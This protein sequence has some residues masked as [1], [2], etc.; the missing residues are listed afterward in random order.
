MPI[1]LDKPNKKKTYNPKYFHPQLFTGSNGKVGLFRESNNPQYL[2]N[3]VAFP[4]ITPLKNKKE[5]NGNTTVTYVP[6]QIDTQNHFRFMQGSH[7]IYRPENTARI[8]TSADGSQHI[9][10]EIT[11]HTVIVKEMFDPITSK[12]VSTELIIL[13]RTIIWRTS[14]DPDVAPLTHKHKLTTHPF[15]EFEQILKTDRYISD[16]TDRDSYELYKENYSLYDAISR[17]AWVWNEDIAAEVKSMIETVANTS[18]LDT[19][20]TLIDIVRTLEDRPINLVAYKEIY[21][22]IKAVLPDYSLKE[23]IRE[24]INLLMAHTL[25]NLDDNRANVPAFP[26]AQPLTPKNP[27]FSKTQ[28]AALSSDAPFVL[29]Q[30][31][32]GSGKTQ[33]LLGRVEHLI[34]RGVDPASITVLSFTNAAAD[35]VL[36][37]NPNVRS[38]TISKM[39]HDIYTYN[40]DHALS[41]VETLINTIDIY[42]P[43]SAFARQFI[44][45]LHNFIKNSSSAYSQMNIF[46]EDNYDEIMS[47]L[48]HIGQTSLE[49]EIIAA[50]QKIDTYQI[51]P[52]LKASHLVIDEVQDTSIF[53]FIYLLK[54]AHEQNATLFLVGDSSQTLFEFRSANPRAINALEA[55][56]VFETYP[57]ETNYRSNQE[58]LDF[59]NL[60]LKDIEA[61]QYA[62]LT[63]QANDL[64]PVTHDSFTKKVQLHYER[65]DRINDMEDEIGPIIRTKVK[66]YIDDIFAR[67]EKVAFLAYTRKQVRFFQEIVEDL[68]PQRKIVSLVPDR[69]YNSTLFSMFLRKYGD[70]LQYMPTKNILAVIEDEI[71][72]RLPLLVKYSKNAE[73]P[74]RNFIFQYKNARRADI[75]GWEALVAQGAMTHEEFIDLLKQ[76]MLSYEISN[77]TIRQALLNQHNE[78]KKKSESI[79]DAD[80]ILSTIHSA[81]GLEFDNVVLLYR[82]NKQIAEGDKRMYYVA[83]TRAM[84]SEYIIVYDTAAKPRIVA[85]YEGLL[86]ELTNR[87]RGVK[88]T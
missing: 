33:V 17:L 38:M 84:N 18:G 64:T 31:V 20:H 35:N 1:I 10:L 79:R 5:N 37:R 21:A 19:T 88:T 48:D 47:I 85:D 73:A 77:N 14:D 70:E 67:N 45:R 59:A 65:L 78:E 12:K 82:S 80:I 4:M 44:G 15:G 69:P 36:A 49:L 63:L 87:D 56:G 25:R 61:N 7:Y 23:V 57:L 26:P 86:H 43:Y 83:L 53:E 50:Y 58:I 54:F 71:I 22:A 32:A 68:Y 2:K 51:P 39:I 28:Q 75:K 46:M 16:L 30:A 42:Y 3:R 66:E 9:E 74:A 60:A 34:K 40:F 52:E 76:D 11:P 8:G 13:Y 41:T 29:T 72:K 81:K 6:L 27:P 24:N 62:H 55:S